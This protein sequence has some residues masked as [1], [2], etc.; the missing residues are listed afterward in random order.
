MIGGWSPKVFEPTVVRDNIAGV[1]G[2]NSKQ[3]IF[4]GGQFNLI[5]IDIYEANLDVYGKR[6]DGDPRFAGGPAQIVS[7]RQAG[8]HQEIIQVGSPRQDDDRDFSMRIA[9]GQGPGHW[10][11]P[12]DRHRG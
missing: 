6:A 12:G 5:P 4:G 11:C 1:V 8:A 10:T 7:Y 9:D 2:K 3:P